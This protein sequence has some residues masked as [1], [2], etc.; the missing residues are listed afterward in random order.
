MAGVSAPLVAAMQLAGLPKLW[1]LYVVRSILVRDCVGMVHGGV[2]AHC[3]ACCARVGH[4]STLE[5]PASRCPVTATSPSYT[6]AA[7]ACRYRW[8]Q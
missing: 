5:Q 3:L 4:I 7:L 8:W 6:T 1:S 2:A